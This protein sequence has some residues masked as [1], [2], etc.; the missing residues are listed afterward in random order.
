MVTAANHA[1][2]SLLM[3]PRFGQALPWLALAS[4]GAVFVG[5]APAQILLGV[6]ILALLLSRLRWQLPSNIGW[7]AGFLAL[8]LLAAMLSPAPASAI[9]QLRK[10]YLWL[11]LP[12]F[13][14]AVRHL[15]IRW[16]L[17]AWALPAFLSALWSFVEFWQRWQ[18]AQQRHTDFYT[19]YVGDRTSGFMSH[20]M[21]FGGQMMIIVL[22]LSAV[23]LFAWP[24]TTARWRAVMFFAAA[25]CGIAMI[26]GWTRS[27]WFGALGGLLYLVA[28]YRPRLLL[29]APPL[30]LLLY[31]VAPDSHSAAGRRNRFQ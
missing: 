27:V 12:L 3:S 19:L 22:L 4:S 26:I 2:L 28:C 21:T 7:L 8:T 17:V 25:I 15:H 6:A 5:V 24:V 9:P 16:L 23:L 31:F 13:I 11:M 14:T 30:L 18:L 1:I 20:W 29:L 10:L